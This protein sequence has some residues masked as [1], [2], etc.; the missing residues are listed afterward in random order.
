M[1]VN[2]PEELEALRRVGR[3]VASTMRA[4]ARRLRPGMTTAELDEIGR[5]ELERHGAR[6]APIATYAFPG[7][8]CISVT[9]EAAHGIPGPREIRAGDLVNIDVS[10]EL[11]GFVADT[12]ASFPVPPVSPAVQALC[13]ATRRALD[14]ALSVVKA[15]APLNRIGQAVQAE[16][17]RSGYTVVRNL[18]GHGVGRGLHEPPR[19][20]ANYYDPSDRRLLTD[21][22][23]LTIEPFLSTGTDFVVE[24][25]NG[26]T[27]TMPD[28]SLVAQYE[29]TVVVTPAGPIVLT[30]AE[31]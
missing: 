31:A 12:G 25:D 4:M 8:T 16:A 13:D 24:Q 21:G 6:S 15:D 11:D 29:H 19:E 10:A 22:L 3:V 2:T 1:S 18:C 20:V 28:G 26:W 17:E 27:L 9:P 30:V 23:V 14:R 5:A 7:A